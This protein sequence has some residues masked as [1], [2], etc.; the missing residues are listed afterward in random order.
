MTEEA[1]KQARRR[2][3]RPLAQLWPYLTRYKPQLFGAIFFLLL[4]AGTTLTLPVAV[5]NVIDQGF[6]ENNASFVGNY[7][8][9]LVIVAGLLAIASASRY[10]FVIWLGERVISDIRKDVFGH[11]AELSPSFFDTAR[12]GE[13]V[14]RLTA[15]TTQIKSAV[16]ATAS[17]ALRNTLLGIGAVGAMVYTS[18]RLSMIVIGAIPLIVF[19]I[20]AFGRAVRRRSRNAQDTLADATSFATEAIS[21][22]RIIQAFAIDKLTA[23][24]FSDAVEVSFEAS[25]KA[26]G[27]RAL[28]T[29]FAI[30]LIF[31]SVIAVLWIGARDVMNGTITPGLLSQFL[32]YAIFA[33]GSLGALSEVWGELSQ[34]AGAAERITELLHEEPEITAPENPQMLSKPVQGEIK[35]DHVDFAYPTKPDEPSVKD[36]SLLI[37]AGE[38]VAVVGPSGAGKS[39]LI[40]L[41]LRFYDPTK[42]SLL[43]D[44][45]DIKRVDPE[46]LRKNIAIVPQ[47][48]VIFAATA[49]D[50]IALGKNNATR[51]EVIAAAKAANADQFITE[52]TR[53][54]EAQL[55]ERGVTLSGGQRQRIAIARAI[56]KDAPI[57]LLDEATSALDAE[58][59]RLVQ[60]ALDTLMKGRTTVVIAHRLATILK[61]DRIV[62]MDK[63]KIVEQGTHATLSKKKNGLYAKLAKLQFDTEWI[64]TKK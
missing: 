3:L 37:K 32:L 52:D 49:H 40:S 48:T 44:C 50:N 56:L 19:P 42:G 16:G 58:S 51:E 10:Y 57:L 55:G 14:S 31:S 64:T 8:S 28:L 1:D 59:E 33:A 53:G 20:I 35:F 62:V 30:F 22:I 6:I 27:T 12:S 41:M 45:T 7:F 5:R 11:V 2:N 54:Y 24:R 61:A 60:D 21:S 17:M 4:A 47:D 25:R 46:E 34:A 38:T 29:A 63:G 36:L 9:A 39:T 18:P 13:I 26:I 15:D 23:N 43:L